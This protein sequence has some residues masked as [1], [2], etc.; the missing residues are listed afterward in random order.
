MNTLQM[1]PIEQHET[2]EMN[3]ILLPFGLLGFERVKNYVLLTRPEEDPFLWLQMVGDT[4][5]AF[6]VVAP[7]FI[8]A[9]YRPDL[10]DLDV[11]FLE[12]NDPTEAFVLNIVTM[13]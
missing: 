2:N 4:K 13:R 10:S 12:L 8:M 5:Q 9:D 6:L 3:V 11:A 7:H 1:M